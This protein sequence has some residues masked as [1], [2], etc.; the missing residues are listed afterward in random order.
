M[1]QA[2]P[3]LLPHVQLVL[4]LA[5]AALQLLQQ[6]CVMT[7]SINRRASRLLLRAVLCALLLPPGPLGD[8]LMQ[9]TDNQLHHSHG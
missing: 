1:K 9:T 4:E 8:C 5:H 2:N 6:L 7:P 3:Y